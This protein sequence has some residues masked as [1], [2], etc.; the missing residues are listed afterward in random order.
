MI[1]FTFGDDPLEAGEPIS[2]QCMIPAG[3]LPLNISWTFNGE[4]VAKHNDIR[5]T[6]N[7]KRASAISID[8]VSEKNI[9]NYTCWGENRAGK[10]SHTAS[11]LV[12]GW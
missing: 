10:T 11:L 9:G 1:P 7:G 8:V 5:T 2:I 6:A 12:N 3:D 4:S